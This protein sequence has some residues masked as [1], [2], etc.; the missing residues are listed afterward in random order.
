MSGR[1][2]RYRPAPELGTQTWRRRGF[3]SRE[4][5]GHDYRPTG[6]SGGGRRLLLLIGVLAVVA[7][8]AYLLLPSA[9]GGVARSL[10]EE[11]P[12]WLRVPLVADAV[13]DDVVDRLDEPA[14][15]DSSPV[16]FVI[17]PGTSARQ[18]TEDLLERGL[19]ADRLAFSYIL[20][21]EDAGSRLQA[22]AHTL[23]RTMTPR[24]VAEVLQ[25]PPAPRVRRAT[26]AL[27]DGLRIE[28]VTAYLLNESWPQFDPADFQQLASQ[29]PAELRADY[30]MLATVPEGRSLEGYLGAGVFEVEQDTDA[31]GFLRT[32]LERRQQEIGHLLDRP[33]PAGLED[34]Y[35]VMTLASIVESETALDEERRL[36]A[37]VYLNRLDREQWQTRLL[38]ADPTVVYGYDTLQLRELELSE[39]VNYVFWAPIGQPMA[40]VQ[41]EDE[42]TGFQT[43]RQ[44]GI[45][46]GPIRS[47]SVASIEAVLEP[48][49][50]DGFLY[51]VAKNDGS[52]SHAFARTF[53]E[54]MRNVER[55]VRGG[56]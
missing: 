14:G 43:Y 15:T 45:P 52:R 55:Y 49:T 56:E 6:S 10:A 18:I 8:G 19:I 46:P 53:E 12:D 13:R 36:V 2:G 9:L 26:V 11:N 37:G 16:E 54:H 27:R 29:P 5:T 50:S 41:L 48:D 42:L 25:Q 3:R 28:Q 24:E 32:L 39:W 7:V 23:D 51:L 34:F 35:D 21:N 33:P 1:R 44:R 40:Q 20:I 4:L 47:P 17:A 22:G 30:E 38:N 31:E